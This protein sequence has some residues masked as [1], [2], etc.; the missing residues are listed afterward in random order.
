LWGVTTDA[1]LEAA[2]SGHGAAECCAS[3]V[4][5]ARQRGGPDNITIQL[6]RMA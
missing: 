2:V 1:E 6:L 3:L 4:E 5:L